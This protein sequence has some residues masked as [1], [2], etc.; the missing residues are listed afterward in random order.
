ML[1]AVGV[2][3]VASVGLAAAA[4][5][6]LPTLTVL[7]LA[8]VLGHAHILTAWLYW[9]LAGKAGG[10]FPLRFLGWALVLFGSY[11]LH[12][13]YGVMVTV[14]PLFFLVHFAFD[15]V[16]LWEVPMDLRNSPVT[17][18]RFLEVAV[19]ILV[20]AGLILRALPDHLRRADLAC[21]P[22]SWNLAPLL[23]GV[24]VVYASLLLRGLHRPDWGSA[25]F[26]GGSAL[27]GVLQPGLR[28]EGL[29]A[30]LILVHVSNWY[31][32]Y[33]LQLTGW[34]ARQL[35]LVRVVGLLGLSAGLFA[36]S[37]WGQQGWLGWFY[38]ETFYDLWTLLHL[39]FSVRLAD[40]RGILRVGPGRR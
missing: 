9:A 38:Q 4:L 23:A 7:Q 34:R 39:I 37:V 19:F 24:G 1:N 17:L 33:F 12:P 15:E 32:H 20:Y 36:V 35:Y 22:L 11:A 29:L 28:Y 8:I 31:V 6:F 14:A 16:H 26:L 25:Y 27:L 3:K 2:E 30:F 40:F 10:A 5:H 18:G 13:W 21:A